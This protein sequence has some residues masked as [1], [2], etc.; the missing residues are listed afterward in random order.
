M[1]NENEQA[2]PA[3]NEP[4]AT[5]ITK[6]ADGQ[7]TM[8]SIVMKTKTLTEEET[9]ASVQP[10]T[11]SE[12]RYDGVVQG[13]INQ[14][15]ID[16]MAPHEGLWRAFCKPESTPLFVSAAV[17]PTR[18]MVRNVLSV[19]SNGQWPTLSECIPPGSVLDLIDA[20]FYKRTDIPR[21]LPFFTVLHYLSAMLLQQDVEIEF[22]GQRVLPD[23]WTIALAPSG[24]GKTFTQSAIAKALG[25]QVK[26][27]PESASAAMFVE[28]LDSNN[29]G[30]WLRDEFA[31]YLN[32]VNTQS[33]MAQVKDYLLRAYDYTTIE[34][35]TKKE[36]FVIEKPAL[37]IFGTTP[38]ATIKNYL[39]AESL[40]DGF[41]QRFAFV[42]AEKDHRPPVSIYDLSQEMPGIVAAWQNGAA[43][44]IHP[45]YRVDDVGRAAF[46]E[47]FG[48]ILSRSGSVGI[49]E[50]FS[51]RI[52]FRS[53][54]YALIYHILLGKK[55]DVLH[56]EDMVYAARVAALNLRD[57][58]RLLD[59]YEVSQFADLSGKA[60]TWIQRVHHEK[61]KKINRSALIAG[62]RGVGNSRNAQDL[63]EYLAESDPALANMIDL[64]KPP[65][66]GFTGKSI[67]GPKP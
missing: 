20:A 2:K 3:N 13:I 29:K 43:G 10:V 49:E 26:L 67:L 48:L 45:V 5:I 53:M 27:F 58:R 35:R 47:A 33:H 41:A 64:G 51:R 62:V 30:L 54:K 7:R 15:V 17:A 36:T 21:E 56:A 11:P 9:V 60:A 50:S 1:S 61:G 65:K 57:L 14:F 23:F 32:Q 16:K 25:G 12:G 34:H 24:A 18:E 6:D 38:L 55:D 46:D 44:T 37:T 40:V 28:S 19:V 4:D 59:Q 63:L 66:S 39:T 31:Q 52:M 22:A 8:H 42:V